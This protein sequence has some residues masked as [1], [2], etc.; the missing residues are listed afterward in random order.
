MYFNPLDYLKNTKWTVGVCYSL[1]QVFVF[2]TFLPIIY[3]ER[4]MHLILQATP[5]YF[6]SHSNQYYLTIVLVYLTLNLI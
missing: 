1:E 4:V 6:L 3:Y 5:S 2:V